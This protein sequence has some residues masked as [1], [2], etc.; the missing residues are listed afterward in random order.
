MIFPFRAVASNLQFTTSILVKYYN[1]QNKR[2]PNAMRKKRKEKKRRERKHITTSVYA[3]L[4]NGTKKKK[5]KTP[6]LIFHTPQAPVSDI[7]PVP[8]LKGLVD[9]YTA[10]QNSFFIL[11]ARLGTF[12]PMM[13]PW[14][15]V[16]ILVEI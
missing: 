8:T 12:L 13:V 10:L 7:N 15:L 6:S 11:S 3:S 9:M 14:L 5:K 2:P 4:S 1:S 16:A